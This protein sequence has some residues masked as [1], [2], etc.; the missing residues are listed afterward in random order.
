M[1]GF[2]SLIKRRSRSRRRYNKRIRDASSK[3]TDF[4]E[5]IME[6]LLM[7]SIGS[8]SL[9]QAT[10][11]SLRLSAPNELIQTSQ[12]EPVAQTLK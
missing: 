2:A 11:T 3:L 9:N 12:A 8:N 5:K 4:K 10:R 6:S 7:K 1:S